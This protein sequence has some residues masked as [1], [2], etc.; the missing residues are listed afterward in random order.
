MAPAER[1]TLSMEN[2]VRCLL[3]FI[4]TLPP[5]KLSSQSTDHLI[6]SQRDTI[7]HHVNSLTGDPNA[8]NA[9]AIAAMQ[10]LAN[11]DSPIPG[12]HKESGG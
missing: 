7:I 11:E 1:R 6:S 3:N 8:L 12:E 4:E 5:I 9:D 2:S 10:M